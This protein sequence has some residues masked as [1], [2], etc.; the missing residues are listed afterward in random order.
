MAR[1]TLSLP[2]L[3]IGAKLWD[4]FVEGFAPDRRNFEV[5][6]FPLV[7]K[8]ADNTLTYFG[9]FV[10]DLYELAR[11]NGSKQAFQ[12]AILLPK[13]A[14][15]VL[16]DGKL[17][18][19]DLR[20]VSSQVSKKL[21]EIA[22][23]SR[24]NQ[25][26][27]NIYSVDRMPAQDLYFN[28]KSG[29]AQS[30]ATAKPGDLINVYGGAR[31]AA[32][33]LAHIE[34]TN[35]EKLLH[36]GLNWMSRAAAVIA[37]VGAGLAFLPAAPIL[38]ALA[39]LST[40]YIVTSANQFD[41]WDRAEAL[42]KHNWILSSKHVMPKKM[43]WVKLAKTLVIAAMVAFLTVEGGLGAYA[44]MVDVLTK[45][46]YFAG[47]L[48]AAPKAL[49]GIKALAGVLSL[50]G[51]I[52]GFRGL[53]VVM[54]N[55]LALGYAK[56]VITPEERAALPVE[57]ILKVNADADS[58]YADKDAKHQVRVL[59]RKVAD[60]ELK[61]NL[62]LATLRA[63]VQSYGD[64]IVKLNTQ[65][66][67]AQNPCVS[68]VVAMKVIFNDL[69]AK[70]KIEAELDG[71]KFDAAFRAVT[72]NLP[73]NLAAWAPAQVFD[74][75]SQE[76]KLKA[77]EDFKAK[78]ARFG[79]YKNSPEYKAYLKSDRYTL[80]KEAFK[81]FLKGETYQLAKP[82]GDCC[83]AGKEALDV[84]GPEVVQFSAVN[85]PAE[86]VATQG[87]QA[88]S[89]ARTALPAENPTRIQPKRAVKH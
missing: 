22:K 36:A 63:D 3:N 88:R 40:Y 17:A 55:W 59:S 52:A 46:P 10:P 60:A 31:Q 67:Q 9:T 39:G 83:C 12:E 69:V 4:Y 29:V 8:N 79:E 13:K 74:A 85:R 75:L 72:D 56:T 44:G 7:H 6:Y 80:E 48:V 65:V 28:S 47:L 54:H 49:L 45:V 71:A 64:E 89:R 27:L 11:A 5:C 86:G 25:E 19:E 37:G 41:F 78:N 23:T 68:K 62:E 58:A 20:S 14:Y 66:K 33:H 70:R 38:G 76:A 16:A 34:E 2:K 57:A 43:D 87:H 24:Q 61:T 42:I 84:Q 18:L 35:K 53:M 1:F 15:P 81:A 77:I 51:A 82:A 26:N 73:M 30:L 50:T 21:F 32:Y